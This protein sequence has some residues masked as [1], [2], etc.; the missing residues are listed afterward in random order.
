MWKKNT[1]FGKGGYM[2]LYYDLF[3]IL[4]E[5]QR[6][7]EKKNPKEKFATVHYI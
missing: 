4:I 6:A 1:Y 3:S 5:S 7:P 2:K